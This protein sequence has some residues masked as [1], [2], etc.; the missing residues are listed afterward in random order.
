MLR[1]ILLVLTALTA[2]LTGC[3]TS[4]GG[5]GGDGGRS[6]GSGGRHAA[7]VAAPSWAAGMPATTPGRLPSEA[8]ETL[9]PDEAGGSYPYEKD[10]TVF[11]DFEGRLPQ[12]S[13][14]YYREYTVPTP[15]SDDRGAR[16]RVTGEAGERYDTSDHDP[17]FTAAVT[18]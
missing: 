5:T 14:G 6:D 4:S 12:R 11:G 15:G 8:R 16:R 3:A 1:K 10:G 13:R 2:L 9:R 18:P 17:T 7:S